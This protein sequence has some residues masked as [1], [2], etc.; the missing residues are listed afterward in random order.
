MHKVDI[1]KRL[2]KNESIR[3]AMKLTHD[4]CGVSEDRDIHSA[5]TIIWLNNVG[6]GRTDF[7]RVEFEAL[8]DTIFG[9]RQPETV[10]H[11]DF[12]F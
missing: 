11:E 4:S 9:K 1:Q 3:R 8:L 12:N 2:A 7:K 6:V 5:K 10:K